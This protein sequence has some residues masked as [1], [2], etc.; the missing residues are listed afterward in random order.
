MKTYHFE[1]ETYMLPITD[2]SCAA[3]CKLNDSEN[4]SDDDRYV[5][6]DDQLMKDKNG[7]DED[8]YDDFDLEHDDHYATCKDVSREELDDTCTKDASKEFHTF[9]NL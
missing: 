2:D 7:I 4:D 5:D 1:N 6:M 9:N 8:H 3:A